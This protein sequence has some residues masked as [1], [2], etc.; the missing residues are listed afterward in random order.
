MA[1]QQAGAI[2]K[3]HTPVN[4]SVRNY[5]FQQ[6]LNAVLTQHNET[7]RWWFCCEGNRF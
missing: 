2:S 4:V 7:T 5:Y 3:I 1:S 6:L